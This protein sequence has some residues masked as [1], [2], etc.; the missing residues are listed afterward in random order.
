MSISNSPGEMMDETNS[1]SLV[2][3]SD[4]HNL[5]KYFIYSQ[6]NLFFGTVKP[7]PPSVPKPKDKTVK[8]RRASAGQMVECMVQTSCMYYN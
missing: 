2:C 5:N 6:V 3:I 4:V 8:P 7:R 1:E